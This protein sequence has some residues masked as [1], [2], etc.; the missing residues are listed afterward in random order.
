MH[1]TR[2][3]NISAFS[4]HEPLKKASKI[5]KKYSCYSTPKIFLK[6]IFKLRFIT[7]LVAKTKKI[8]F[9]GLKKILKIFLWFFFCVQRKIYFLSKIFLSKIFFAP[10]NFLARPSVPAPMHSWR[11]MHTWPVRS[12]PP[13]SWR[14]MHTWPVRSRPPPVP[15]PA[16]AHTCVRALT[17]ARARLRGLQCAHARAWPRRAMVGVVAA[18]HIALT[19]AYI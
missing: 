3:L 12:R 7:L 6:K 17:P 5:R 9:F 8:L 4:I 18:A 14:R 10:K 13:H 1:P 16:P 15:P 19:A 2:L 11:R